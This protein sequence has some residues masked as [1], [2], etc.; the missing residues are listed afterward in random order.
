MLPHLQGGHARAF[1]EHFSPSCPSSCPGRRGPP[2]NSFSNYPQPPPT[3]MPSGRH[4]H[5][6]KVLLFLDALRKGSWIALI[7]LLDHIC[8]PMYGAPPLDASKLHP[9]FS[10]LFYQQRRNIHHHSSRPQAPPP[11]PPPRLPSAAP[12]LAPP[13]PPALSMMDPARTS[14]IFYGYCANQADK[15]KM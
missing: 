4:P 14:P 2:V 5:L 7:K 12:A 10:G 3:M 9:A 8:L 1:H 13:P 15:A 11:P 6:G